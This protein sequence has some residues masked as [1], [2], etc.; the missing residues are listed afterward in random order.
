ME[1]QLRT[2]SAAVAELNSAV[3]HLTAEN[4]NLRRQL[5][6][7]YPPAHTSATAAMTAA[8]PNTP[9]QAVAGA[10]AASAAPGGNPA[11]SGVISP[12]PGSGM[13]L[14]HALPGLN[15]PLGPLMHLSAPHL[16]VAGL[17]GMMSAVPPV[18]I[19]KL[20]SKST[21]SKA[22]GARKKT[23]KEAVTAGAAAGAAAGGAGAGAGSTVA[24]GCNAAAVNAAVTGA[25]SGEDCKEQE[26]KKGVKRQRTESTGE[27]ALAAVG[28][29]PGSSLVVRSG[30]S[31]PAKVGKKGTGSG[32]S[33]QMTAK[34]P[35]LALAMVGCLLVLCP[36]PGSPPS[37]SGGIVG[38][39]SAG[40]G[41]AGSGTA[42]QFWGEGG[43]RGG[44][45]VWGP[46]Q[47]QGGMATTSWRPQRHLMAL[48]GGEGRGEE[49]GP[50]SGW[51]WHATGSGSMGERGALRSVWER[52]VAGK[53]WLGL[54]SVARHMFAAPEDW[55]GQAGQWA[56]HISSRRGIS[57]MNRR[58]MDVISVW[59]AAMSVVREGVSGS[60]SAWW[61]RRVA[62]GQEV[63]RKEHNSTWWEGDLL[64]GARGQGRG[65]ASEQ[66]GRQG[67]WQAHGALGREADAVGE[68]GSEVRTAAASHR[69]AN[70]VKGT[71]VYGGEK[72]GVLANTSGE[73]AV[74]AVALWQQQ[75][76]QLRTRSQEHLKRQKP[77]H[78]PDRELQEIKAMYLVQATAGEQGLGVVVEGK[79]ARHQRQEEG[80]LDLQRQP[81]TREGAN[82]SHPVASH[83]V[84]PARGWDRI[85][86][87]QASSS[88]G[89]GP[90]GRMHRSGSSPGHAR[91]HL[92]RPL[93]TPRPSRL[94]GGATAAVFPLVP[95]A[96]S[97]SSSSSSPL[98]PQPLPPALL[99]VQPG[100]ALAWTALAALTPAQRQQ[101]LLRLSSGEPRHAWVD[102]G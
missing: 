59:A 40:A 90:E 78:G 97:S 55:G 25:S 7:Y 94:R 39:D 20:R 64:W 76:Q 62:G 60:A 24:A 66:G 12:P 89:S 50:L 21:A 8:P 57:R 49:D 53:L 30:G 65:R 27:Q 36:L 101:W 16:A 45:A 86:A 73:R 102:G 87:S 74:G 17:R 29:P 14:P 23:G 41:L 18:P 37:L 98:P 3:A 22:S 51:Q 56:G 46:Q 32:S 96:A 9:G 70:Q 100:S 61:E 28:Q 99:P 72:R 35:L 85:N 92:K 34:S 81:I 26:E 13:L 44:G 80:V 71:G 63:T 95:R 38:S 79:G 52:S 10:G 84:G 91:Q 6:L 31:T 54:C 4:V 67:G 75:Q 1:C 82:A 77:G 68:K 83:V 33:V 69:A 42:L 58:G 11:S 19:P 88:R 48:E 93:H 43:G 47:R 15:R 2:L 5:A